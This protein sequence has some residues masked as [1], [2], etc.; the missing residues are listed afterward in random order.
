MWAVGTFSV[1]DVVQR[2]L[3]AMGHG[4][5]SILSALGPQ[6]PPGARA[7]VTLTPAPCVGVSVG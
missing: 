5:N 7:V 3:C 6:K 1:P 2:V 4:L